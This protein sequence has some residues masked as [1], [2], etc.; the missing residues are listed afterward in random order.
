MADRRPDAAGAG[1]LLPFAEVPQDQHRLLGQEAH[2]GKRAFLFGREFHLAQ[3]FVFLQMGVQF[4]EQLHFLLGQ[5]F[6]LHAA[7]AQ[8]VLQPLEFPLD[9]DQ[10]VDQ[11]FRVPSP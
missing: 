2:P 1:F 11:E 10:V 9:G 4:L 7:F 8:F 3:G 6:I 5:G